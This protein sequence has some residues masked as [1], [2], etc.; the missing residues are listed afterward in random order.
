MLVDVLGT[1]GRALS[2]LPIKKCPGVRTDAPSSGAESSGVSG[3]LFNTASTSVRTV[4]IS[5]Q[6]R[7]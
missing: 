6:V 2:D 1:S 3:R 5:S 4:Y 7:R